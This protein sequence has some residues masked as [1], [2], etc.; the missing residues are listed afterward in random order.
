MNPSITA[1][2]TITEDGVTVVH[3]EQGKP[4]LTLRLALSII[5]ATLRKL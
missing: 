2:I 3:T 1:L 4:D 5:I